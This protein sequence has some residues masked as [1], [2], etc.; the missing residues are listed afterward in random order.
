MDHRTFPFL[1]FPYT[2][3]DHVHQRLVKAGLSLKLLRAIWKTNILCLAIKMFSDCFNVFN[4]LWLI[5][6]RDCRIIIVGAW[7]SECVPIMDLSLSSHPKEVIPNMRRSIRTR[8]SLSQRGLSS[9]PYPLA[10]EMNALTIA[11][12]APSLCA[13][14]LLLLLLL[15]HVMR[16]CRGWWSSSRGLVNK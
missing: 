2:A 15:L 14:L 13:K 7:C 1:S 16:S 6:H 11:P 5:A 10:L 12:S 8:N 9:N 4:V 3:L